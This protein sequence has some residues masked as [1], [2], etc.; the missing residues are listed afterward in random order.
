LKNDEEVANIWNGM[1]R[2]IRLTK[3][4]FMDKVIEDV[5]KYHDGLFKVKVEKF[6]KQ[7]VFSSWKLL[8]LLASILFLLLAFL[9]AFCS[10]YDCA[11]LFH[12]H[13]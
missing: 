10:V 9:Q 11:R 2:S 7:Y 5:N 1:S 3:V 12:I 8:R 6:M 13:Y 4:P